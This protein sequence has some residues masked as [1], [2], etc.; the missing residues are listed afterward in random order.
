M[1][2]DG[3]VEINFTK[4]VCVNTFYV[5]I[6]HVLRNKTTRH[7]GLMAIR[8]N[9]ADNIPFKVRPSGTGWYKTGKLSMQKVRPRQ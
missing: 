4:K 6:A 8:Y 1:S 7:F 3:K 9:Y 2:Q 5:E